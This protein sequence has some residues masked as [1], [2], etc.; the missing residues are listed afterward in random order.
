MRTAARTN[1]GDEFVEGVA[2]AE[3]S[4]DH[5]HAAAP[6]REGER[7]L[8]QARQMLVECG[9]VDDGDALLAAQIR[10]PRRERDDF[11]AGSEADTKGE[12]ILVLVL[13]GDFL[14]CA[15]GLVET[16][17]PSGG[18]LDKLPPPIFFVPAI[19]PPRA[20]PPPPRPP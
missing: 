7:S 15:G 1:V 5:M 9:F 12:D 10:R 4:R 14:D 17:G 8:N 16:A 18:V 19:P 2:G 6:H 20:L 11:V 3:V 13:D